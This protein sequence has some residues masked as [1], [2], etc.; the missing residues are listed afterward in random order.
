MKEKIIE[1]LNNAKPDEPIS[2]VVMSNTLGISR[3]AIWKH[4]K[5]L[6]EN[7]YS[8]ISTPK[9]Y[10]LQENEDLLMPLFFTKRKEQIH[11]FHTLSSTMDKAREFAREGVPNFSVVIAEVQTKGRGRLNRMW[12]SDKGGL[13]FTLILRPDLPPPFAFQVNFAA[14]LSLAKILKQKYKLDVS[15]KWPNDILINERD[16]VALNE[17]W[18]CVN[19]G[20]KFNLRVEKKLAGLLSEM[21]TQGDMISF[22]SIGIGLNVNNSPE[23]NQPNAVSI[24]NILGHKICRREL[25]SSFLDEFENHLIQ[26]QAFK[27]NFVGIIEQWKLM[28]STIGRDVIIETFGNIYRGQAIDVDLTGALIIRQEDGVEKRIIYGDCFYHNPHEIS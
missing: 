17:N 6:R 11:F 20:N 3:V 8:I 1:I 18:N 10:F 24:S 9:G 2:G 27:N 26:I 19:H 7:G 21:E 13:W 15:V 22:V 28:T 12:S 16:E 25:L 4:L 5:Q 14:S 23:I